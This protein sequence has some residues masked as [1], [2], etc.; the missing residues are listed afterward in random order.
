LQQRR[1]LRFVLYDTLHDKAV[2]C[3]LAPEHEDLMRDAWGRLAEVTGMVTRDPVTDRPR[4]VRQVTDVR[5][6]EELDRYAFRAARGAIQARPD[7]PPSEDVI[8]RV[9]DAV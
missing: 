5:V 6:I 2:I 7:A 1:G 8:R 3:Y 4:T 9:R